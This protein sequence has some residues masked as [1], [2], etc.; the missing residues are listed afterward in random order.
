M[1]TATL[2]G[3]NVLALAHFCSIDYSFITSKEPYIGAG[4]AIIGALVSREKYYQQLSEKYKNEKY[5]TLKGLGIIAY[6]CASVILY[7]FSLF[8]VD[9]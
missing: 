8:L 2:L 5:K 6:A 9:R 1:Y 3:M 7:V 4:F